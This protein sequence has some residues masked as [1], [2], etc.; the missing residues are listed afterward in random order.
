MKSILLLCFFLLRLVAAAQTTVSGRVLDAKSGNGL[1][2]VT[3]L[4][5]G[6]NNGFS[7]IYDGSFTLS[8]PGAPDSVALAVSYIGH[9]PQQRWV[10]AGSNT[11]IRL[12]MDTRGI[13]ECPVGYPKVEV[14]LASGLRYTPFGG[15]IKLDGPA[16]IRVPLTATASYQTNFARNHALSIGLGLPPIRRFHRVSLTETLEYQ[17]LRAPSAHT[18]FDSYS[19]IIGLSVGYL[20]GRRLPTFLLG[21]GYA[22]WHP[23]EAEAASIASGYGYAFGLRVDNLPLNLYGAVKATRWPVYWQWQARVSHN[24]PLR[25]QASVELNQLRQ[26]TELSVMLTRSFH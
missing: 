21:A 19:G 24:L 17:Q 20:G 22:Q 9:A 18:R 8:V 15:S 11:V 14:G 12:V 23:R 5:L 26:Y 7:S 1:P 16:L 2:G 10:A 3:I 25:L 13:I 6:T 4:Q